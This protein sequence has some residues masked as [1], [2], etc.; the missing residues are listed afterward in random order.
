MKG[1]NRKGGKKGKGTPIHL[2]EKLIEQLSHTV[3]EEG[4]SENHYQ[5]PKPADSSH[6]A[7]SRRL[8]RRNKKQEK[9]EKK[10]QSHEFKLSKFQ[11][12]P[13]P[14]SSLKKRK[15]L[16]YEE[17]ESEKVYKKQK[18]S[19]S[20]SS[21]SSSSTSTSASKAKEGKKGK[22]EGKKGKEEKGKYSQPTN[23]L[24]SLLHKDGLIAH[25]LTQEGIDL[26]TQDDLDIDFYTRKLK[27]S[28]KKTNS[29]LDS[30]L[31][32]PSFLY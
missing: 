12:P 3:I 24:F 27:S 29:Q 8:Q 23:N 4:D 16:P 20:S 2:P 25:S 31:P 19:S 14:P 21:S 28:S 30:P 9:K 18:I 5:L 26:K 10:K 22:E 6:F 13:P 15:Q 7:Q 1:K 32:P 17:E 11:H